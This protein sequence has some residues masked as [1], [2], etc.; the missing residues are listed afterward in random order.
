MAQRQRA[1]HRVPS[2]SDA[3]HLLRK[4]L[5]SRRAISSRRRVTYSNPYISPSS[6]SHGRDPSSSPPESPRQV[7]V[8]LHFNLRRLP[9]RSFGEKD[10]MRHEIDAYHRTLAGTKRKRVV[11]G[12]ENT[13]SGRGSRVNRNKRRKA[14]HGSSD[15]E[16]TSSMEVDDQSHWEASD[17]SEGE[18]DVDSC[19]ETCFSCVDGP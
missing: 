8:P 6:S 16:V 2:V 15:D 5:K 4:N 10:S 19:E 7:L 13:A 17:N 18:E 1:H 11:S 9:S 12:A 14:T 3:A